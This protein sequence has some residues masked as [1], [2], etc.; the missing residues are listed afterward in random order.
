MV[1]MVVL[2]IMLIGLATMLGY[3]TRTW[4]NAMG[5]VDNFTKARLMLSLQDRDIQ[6]MVLRPDMAAFVNNSNA[7]IPACAFYT[8][9]QGNEGTT[10]AD[11]RNLSLV[12][13]YLNL[14]NSTSP[15]IPAYTLVRRAYGLGF[16]PNSTPTWS[17]TWNTIVPPWYTSLGNTN[18]LSQLGNV[19]SSTQSENLITGV[20]AYQWQFVDGTGT[21]LSPP[22]IPTGAT[23]NSTYPF[24]YNFTTPT[25]NANPRILVI[26]MVVL[27]GSAYSLATKVGC[28][29]NV[30]ADFPT[31]LPVAGT[32]Q[33]Y[34]QYW[35]SIFNSSTNFGATLPEPV[36]HGIQVFER[37]IPLPVMNPTF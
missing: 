2:S 14:T 20:I 19:S 31:N 32:N 23:T 30:V 4:L 22:Y 13:Y 34:S 9:V 8:R 3:V 7:A 5:S 12:Q 11:A 21:I 17:T 15:N 6:M 10:T 36:R 37:H 1:A 28:L 16:P 27:S 35:N 33:T 25:T 18:T 29:T 26:S 24:H